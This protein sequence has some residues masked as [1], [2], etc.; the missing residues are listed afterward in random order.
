[1]FVSQQPTQPF[2]VVTP[3]GLYELRTQYGPDIDALVV[4][5]DESGEPTGL[6]LLYALLDLPR[7]KPAFGKIFR[8]G[9]NFNAKQAL[10]DHAGGVVAKSAYKVGKF[11]VQFVGASASTDLH[12]DVLSPNPAL[13]V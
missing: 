5:L 7:N 4:A 10:V 8:M 13:V 12:S 1:M 2:L 9:S 3:R 6:V 11:K